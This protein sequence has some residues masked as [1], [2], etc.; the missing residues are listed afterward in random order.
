MTEITCLITTSNTL[1][2]EDLPSLTK[3]QVKADRNT[4]S[5]SGYFHILL[6]RASSPSSTTHHVLHEKSPYLL[7]LYLYLRVF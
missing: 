1:L 4:L 2:L 6:R 7:L 3:S 5:F